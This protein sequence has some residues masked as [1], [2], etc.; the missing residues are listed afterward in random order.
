VLQRDWD[1]PHPLRFLFVS[2]PDGVGSVL[3]IVQ[4][5]ITN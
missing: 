3:A 4:R 2:K 1:F 5:V